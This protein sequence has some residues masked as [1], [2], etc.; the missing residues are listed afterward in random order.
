MSLVFPDA[1]FVCEARSCQ[2]VQLVAHQFSS[3]SHQLRTNKQNFYRG[4]GRNPGSDSRARTSCAM[5]K[6]WIHISGRLGSPGA[7]GVGQFSGGTLQK[8]TSRPTFRPHSIRHNSYLHQIPIVVLG[9]K[10]RGMVSHY[11]R[12]SWIGLG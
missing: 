9:M 3:H 4:L 2:D 11:F 6:H 5:N 1:R 8:G 7:E 12:W 10:I